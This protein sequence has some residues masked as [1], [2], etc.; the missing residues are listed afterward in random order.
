MDPLVTLLPEVVQAALEPRFVVHAVLHLLI[1]T[2]A[3]ALQSRGVGAGVMG[4]RVAGGIALMILGYLFGGAPGAVLALGAAFSRSMDLKP[5]DATPVTKAQL[6]SAA[7]RLWPFGVAALI[8]AVGFGL[9]ITL[10][11]G[12]AYAAVHLG[13]AASYGRAN[14]EAIEAGRPIGKQNVRVELGQGAA[15]G[16]AIALA[17][18]LHP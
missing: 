8:T 3:F 15:A 11:L 2:V 6:R 13:L 10:P 14:A 7:V 9:W 17:L 12:A 16:L 1:F 4:A 5:G 18:L